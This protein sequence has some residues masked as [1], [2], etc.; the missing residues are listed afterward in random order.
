[1]PRALLEDLIITLDKDNNNELDYKELSK[2]LEQFRV[3]RRRTDLSLASTLGEK[4]TVW[5]LSDLSL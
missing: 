1:M 5:N 3:E 4:K 2:G